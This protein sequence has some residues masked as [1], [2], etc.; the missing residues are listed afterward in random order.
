MHPLMN[1]F[2]SENSIAFGMS[3]SQRAAVSNAHLSDELLMGI[4]L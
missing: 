1:P 2:P 3:T 4:S